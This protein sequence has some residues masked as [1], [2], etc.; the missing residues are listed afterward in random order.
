MKGEQSRV[1]SVDGTERIPRLNEPCLC[2][3]STHLFHQRAAVWHALF[4]VA[5]YQAKG[6]VARDGDLDSPRFGSRGTTRDEALDVLQERQ[7][8]ALSKISI[9]SMGKEAGS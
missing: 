8:V 9:V 3:H 1:K 5:Q 4:L 7:R 2:R 6:P